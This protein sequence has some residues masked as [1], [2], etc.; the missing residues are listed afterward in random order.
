[1]ERVEVSRTMGTNDI[2]SDIT[3]MSKEK[4]WK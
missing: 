4:G 1:M 3:H 2:K